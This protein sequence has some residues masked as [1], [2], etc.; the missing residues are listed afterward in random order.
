[1]KSD[2]IEQLVIS[3]IGR[4]MCV[5][6]SLCMSLRLCKSIPRFFFISFYQNLVCLNIVLLVNFLSRLHCYIWLNQ[7]RKLRHWFKNCR[8]WFEI[9]QV[10]SCRA[11]K[12]V[13]HT[14]PLP[15]PVIFYVYRCQLQIPK[16]LQFSLNSAKLC[17]TS[18]D[19]A[20]A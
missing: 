8:K 14:E 9:Q 13:L 10:A 16:N 2:T 15:K 11:A 6:A 1:M 12:H 3:V 18:R 4:C 5:E 19:Q 17:H 7:E 20:A